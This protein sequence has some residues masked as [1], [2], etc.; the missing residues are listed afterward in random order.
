VNQ[1]G[2]CQ[3]TTAQRTSAKTAFVGAAA[4]LLLGAC[5]AIPG[6]EQVQAVPKDQLDQ[7][8]ADKPAEARR[9]Y[10]RVPLEGKRNET[11]NHMRAGLAALELGD[12]A[13]AA[14]SFDVALDQIE[15]VYADSPQAAQAR[16]V[17]T[18]ENY[19][20]F[21][22][23]PYERGMA[24]YYRGLVYMMT[25]DYENA[26]ASFRGG[27]LQTAFSNDE[28]YD[29]DF[30]LLTYLSGWAAR[31]A[32]AGIAADDAFTVARR[33]NPAL[34]PPAEQDGLL[35]LAEL[36]NAPVKFANGSN[37]ELLNF[38]AGQE[39]PERVVAIVGE[40]EVRAYSGASLYH[41]ATVRGG[42]EIDGV[43]AG[44][45]QF[46]E[47]TNTV[48]TAATY[49]GIAVMAN[50]RNRD[51]ANAG[52]FIALAGLLGQAAAAAMRP[53]ADTR[54]WDNIP[55]FIHVATLPKV[56][57]ASIEVRLL[58]E[59]GQEL[60]R[61]PVKVVSQGRCSVAWYR[62]RSALQV[63]DSAPGAIATK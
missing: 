13:N 44:K 61:A 5:A 3:T 27:V 22:G 36:G 42:R 16:S 51:E 17:W 29:A 32:G 26:R 48:A 15:A 39:V 31:C 40:P 34:R 23:E 21:K 45:A 56:E 19:K 11:L 60:R 59:S 7:Y 52:A 54:T 47:T 4:S 38:A 10:A 57:G 55:G 46:K 63:P 28:R 25:G 58:T 33:S 12:T 35:V 30:A 20:D 9:L 49:A 53:D 6:Y 14:R 18:K 62:A 50:A 8:L 1:S 37:R 2:A 41:Q 43:L 24:Y